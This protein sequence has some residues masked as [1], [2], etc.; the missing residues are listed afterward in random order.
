VWGEQPP[1]ERDLEIRKFES[2]ENTLITNCRVLGRG[3][4]CP[5]VNEIFNAAPTKH[6]GTFL[7]GLG[8]GTRALTGTLDG[9]NTAEERIAAIA[10]SA[11]P[12]WDFHDI[13]NTSRF[14]SPVTAIDMLLAGPKEIIDKIKE[15]KADEE[16]TL[17]ELDAA[18]QAELDALKE[19]ERLE[20]EAERERRKSCVVGVTFDSRSRD[21]F[22]KPDVKTP[23]IKGYYVPF[24]KWKR[25]PLR[26]PAI[27]LS[28]LQ[29]A[30]RDAKLSAMWTVAFRQEVDRRMKAL[31]ERGVGQW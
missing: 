24:G 7:Q 2:G 11:K 26:D 29:W 31:E 13:T 22:D 23:K 4:D 30:L 9:L 12:T 19:M 25:R 28:W 3:W 17:D 21:L 5:M 6:K 10:A 14:H 15:D 20:R 8:R 16:V 1:E 18:L 27:P